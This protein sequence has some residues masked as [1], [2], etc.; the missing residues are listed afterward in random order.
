MQISLRR[1]RVECS[2]RP[3]LPCLFAGITAALMDIPIGRAEPGFQSGFLRQMPGQAEHIGAWALDALAEDRPLVPGPYQ[4]Q[5]L[6]NLLPVGLYTLEFTPADDGGLQP[7]LPAA[8]LAEWGLRLEALE[9]LDAAQAACLDLA[10]T[11]P[12]AQVTFTP[13][14]LQLAI[15]I[16]QIALRRE[17]A[18]H[19]APEHWDSGINAA[20]IN[21]QAS[22]QQ[23]QSR[24]RGHYAS[25]DLYLS[26]GLNL[27]PWRLRSTQS[28]RHDGQGDTAWTRGQTYAQRDLPGTH[29]N[30][31]LGE[32]FTDSDVFRGV[33][34]TGLRIASDLSMLPDAQ[35]GY[36]P[37]IR[38]V[39][40]SRS[41]LEIWQN[42][43]PIYST[44]VSQG[45]Y[46]I[47]DL[48]TAGSGELEVVLTEED[49]QVQRYTQPYA[50]LANQ[51][52]QGVWRYSAT[53]GR[54]N[55]AS[56]QEAPLLW[57]GTLA[58][59]THWNAT[60][61]GGVMASEYYRAAALG[62]SKDLGGIGALAFDVTRS[63][64][65]FDHDGDEQGMSYALRYGKTFN[66][67][68]SLRFAGYRYST[69]GYRDF[70]EAVR[71][72]DMGGSFQGSRR[73]RLEASLHQRLLQS[74]SLTL[75][76]SQQDYWQR[77]A[78]QRQYQLN[79]STQHRGVTYNLFAS[80]SLTDRRGSDRQFGLSLSLPLDIGHS[81]RATFDLRNS[82]QGYSQRASLSGSSSE[83]I[84]YNASL[85]QDPQHNKAAS[86]ALGYRGSHASLGA[87]FT[88]ADDY[89]N[90]SLNASGALLVHGQGMTF[91]PYMGDTAGLIEVPEVAGVGL[92]NAAGTRTNERGFAIVPSLQ[93]YR[94]NALELNTDRVGLEVQ[95]DNG[96]AQVV[97]RRG[98]VVKHR[99]EARRIARLVLTL[100][101]A[102]GQPL[103][104]G[105]QVQ[106]SE[107]M[108][109]GMVG[110]AGQVLLATHDEPQQ[111]HVSW[112]EQA[113]SRCQLALEPKAIAL[114][115]GYRLH[116]Q[117][118]L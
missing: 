18:G 9:D 78:P 24:Y 115:E 47:D 107:G 45:P 55:P 86:L 87:G 39:A 49:G 80:Q 111:L 108:A 102:Q 90:L 113:D 27:G 69:P 95:I 40:R 58:M 7:C 15:S 30:L 101:D 81:S 21:Y 22:T 12:G 67:Q 32:T 31:T 3:V 2:Q 4:V 104:F 91:G 83:S 74:S 42:G 71:Q 28:W 100:H 63:L 46:A 36:A 106:D 92:L 11:V 20:F 56:S 23:G 73:S 65:E 112:G 41:K 97:P 75:T 6:V 5:V 84:S 38:G 29:A 114:L 117:A 57:Q 19:V 14:R 110:Q 98:A 88:E 118:C 8:Q 48:S 94:R 60:L 43:Y 44:Y 62:I 79:F 61:Y 54:Y 13:G 51:L 64:A 25:H 68:T 89:R 116:S 10:S 105:A 35:Q 33:P 93:P 26:S 76:L 37:I 34:I 70:D 109:L 50:T 66:T 59:G 72:R 16:P 82:G 17:V 77:M 53:L 52:R 1:W 99:F 96:T 103:P 85:S